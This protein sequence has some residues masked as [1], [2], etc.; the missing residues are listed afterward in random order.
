M[1]IK[2]G[3]YGYGPTNVFHT[4]HIEK[5]AIYSAYILK[6]VNQ[7]GKGSQTHAHE[8]CHKGWRLNLNDL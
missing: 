8:A 5:V 7:I 4:F 3:R 6:I 1:P 2:Q